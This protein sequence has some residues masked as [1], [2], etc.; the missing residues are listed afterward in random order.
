MRLEYLPASAIYGK[1]NAGNGHAPVVRIAEQL[2]V[3]VAQ[4][5]LVT[6]K[7]VCV[8]RLEQPRHLCRNN[9]YPQAGTTGSSEY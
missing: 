9:N 1:D 8:Q 3:T 4:V 5:M 2:Q 6:G 7:G